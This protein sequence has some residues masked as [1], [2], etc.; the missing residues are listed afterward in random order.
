MQQILCVAFSTSREWDQQNVVITGSTDGVVRMWSI[1][2]VQVPIGENDDHS[3]RGELSPNNSKNDNSNEI[4]TIKSASR[5]EKNTMNTS[6]LELI[7]KMS[8]TTQEDHHCK[9]AYY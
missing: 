3:K 4:S 6:A 2:Y 7:Q 8:L 5:D 9:H 1:E